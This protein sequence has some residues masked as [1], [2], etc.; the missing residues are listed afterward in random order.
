MAE[1]VR[2]LDERNACARQ[3]DG[4]C[5]TQVVES[6]R[7]VRLAA[8]DLPLLIQRPMRECL[9]CGVVGGEHCREHQ[10]VWC[11]D[12]RSEGVESPS[13]VWLSMGEVSPPREA[14]NLD[15][16]P[17]VPFL[18]S[19]DRGVVETDGAV[20]ARFGLEKLGVFDR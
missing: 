1:Q 6:M 17:I 3:L 12:S 15:S 4:E 20:S 11:R 9:A 2:D 10:S 8:D 7:N 13:D 16:E 14:F 5:V 19:G 18:Q